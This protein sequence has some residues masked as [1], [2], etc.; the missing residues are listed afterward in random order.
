MANKKANGEGSIYQRFDGRWCGSGYVLAADGSSRRIYVYGVTRKEAADKLTDKLADSNRGLV[1]AKDP[2]ITVAEYLTAWLT[3]VARQRLRATTYVTYEGLIRRHLIPGLGN[4]RLGALTVTEVRT[5]LDKIQTVC[6]CC[7][8][9][10]DV[11]RDPND[12][13]PSKRPRCCA[14]GACCHQTIKPATVRYIRAVLSAA[15]ADG[16]REDLLGRN[17]ASSIRLPTPRSDFQPFTAGEARRYLLAAAYHRHN[18]LYELALRTGLRK[19]ELL[20][21]QWSDIDLDA[22]HLYV[23]RTLARTKGRPTFQPVKTY[24]SARRISVPRECVA[25]LIR[26]RSR[27]DIDR[28]AAGDG[29]KD[30]GLV[31]TNPSGG[32]MDPVTVFRNH[33]TICELADVR[34]IRFHDLRHTCATLLLEQGVDLVTIKDLLGHAQIHTTADIYSHVRLRLQRRAIESM[35]QALQ[36]DEDPDDDGDEPDDPLVP[37]PV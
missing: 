5:F 29:W 22:G 7:T 19:G 10:W 37:A 32:P 6:Q 2:T 26:Y 34:Y 24:R 25:S 28:R 9:G 12:K 36:P 18:A 30:N 33:E 23:K 3:T 21:L 14:I 1:I 4:R 27:Q 11:A 15:L 20:G 13:Q 8:W 35:G 17:V 31:F 16:V